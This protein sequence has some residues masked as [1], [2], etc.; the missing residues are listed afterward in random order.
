MAGSGNFMVFRGR[1]AA[2]VPAPPSAV[3]AD[4]TVTEAPLGSESVQYLS[5]SVKLARVADGLDQTSLDWTD[6]CGAKEWFC[7][8]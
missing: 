6:P 4:T 2:S 5:L 8:L 7:L 3:R 1:P